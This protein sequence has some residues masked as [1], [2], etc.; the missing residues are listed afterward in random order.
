LTKTWPFLS[1]VKTQASL[2]WTV[3]LLPFSETGLGLSAVFKASSCRLWAVSSSVPSPAAML[4]VA[5]HVARTQ[6]FPCFWGPFVETNGAGLLS[7]VT[8]VLVFSALFPLLSLSKFWSVAA[9]LAPTL[10]GASDA[11][12]LLEPWLCPKAQ[13]TPGDAGPPPPVSKP[14]TANNE[15]MT[16][17]S[18]SWS[19]SPGSR[20]AAAQVLI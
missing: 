7:T 20:V 1:R 14:P 16:K 2:F 12:C 8:A 11:S 3:G 19:A 4:A 13:S 15:A 6:K 9:Q 18:N 10:T 17:E 5:A